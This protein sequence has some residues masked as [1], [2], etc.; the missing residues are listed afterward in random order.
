MTYAANEELWWLS[1]VTP[2]LTYTEV[3]VFG[4]RPVYIHNPNHLHRVAEA[5]A[6]F[7]F[8]RR[9]AV[10][11]HNFVRFPTQRN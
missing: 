8:T 1:S 3:P 5:M 4:L 10:T 9:T 7:Q 6:L 11:R 2:D